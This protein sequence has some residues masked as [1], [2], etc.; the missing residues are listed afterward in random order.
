[1]ERGMIQMYLSGV[2]WT[3]A[4]QA[5]KAGSLYAQKISTIKVKNEFIE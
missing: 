2:R 4:T 1:M 5:C 3:K